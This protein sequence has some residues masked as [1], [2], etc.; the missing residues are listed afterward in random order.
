MLANVWLKRDG[1]AITEWPE[2]TIGSTSVIRREYVDAI[3][4]ADDGD[5]GPL[6]VLHQ[7]FTPGS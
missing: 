5:E 6:R 2:E 4:A 1:H 7:R 3:R